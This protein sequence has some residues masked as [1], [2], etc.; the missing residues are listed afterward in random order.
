[1]GGSAERML[2]YIYELEPDSE[3]LAAG[4]RPKERSAAHNSKG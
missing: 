2:Y 1:M 4:L 3:Y